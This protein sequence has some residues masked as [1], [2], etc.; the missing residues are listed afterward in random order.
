MTDYPLQDAGISLRLSTGDPRGAALLDMTLPGVTLAAI[1]DAQSHDDALSSLLVIG[2]REAVKPA[3]ILRMATGVTD[4]LAGLPSGS[5]GDWQMV[6]RNGWIATFPATSLS[7]TPIMGDPG[8][9]T[10]TLRIAPPVVL[11]DTS[12][13]PPEPAGF[14][15]LTGTD[16]QYLTAADGQY[17]TGVQDT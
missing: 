5:A 4:W 13:L 10:V 1:L 12:H 8:T 9:Y 3:A 6:F 14:T 16:G 2:L 11:L 7:V 17:L 15:F